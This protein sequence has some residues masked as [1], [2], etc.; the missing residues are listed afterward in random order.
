[1]TMT[2][3]IHMMSEDPLVA[4]IERLPDPEDQFLTC[5]NPR[6][7][8]QNPLTYLLPEVKTLLLP[9]HRIHCIEILP[10]QEE[11]ELVTFVRE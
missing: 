9:W 4:E 2:V 1:M 11:E 6:R 3:L 7:R 5:T 10:S 8:D